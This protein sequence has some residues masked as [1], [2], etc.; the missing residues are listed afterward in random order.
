M[1]IATIPLNPSRFISYN[2]AFWRGPRNGNGLCGD[3]E[4]NEMS[5]SL[6]AVNVEDMIFL[7]CLNR[8]EDAITGEEKL[9]RL[10]NSGRIVYGTNVFLGFW[11]D[12]CSHQ[13]KLESVLD[14]LFYQKCITSCID[15]PGDV[16]RRHNGRRCVLYLNRYDIGLWGWGFRSLNAECRHDNLSAVSQRVFK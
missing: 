8:S 12:Y 9:V 10:N 1:N 2:W 16:L 4:R 6:K 11:N 7:N 14:R 15:F 3:E 5:L 13:N